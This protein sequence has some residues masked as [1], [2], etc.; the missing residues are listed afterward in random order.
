M[1]KL[2][3]R[4]KFKSFSIKIKDFVLEGFNNGF[5]TTI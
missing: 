1:I 2:S 5:L 4:K 3:L